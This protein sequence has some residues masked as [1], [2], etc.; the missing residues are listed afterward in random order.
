MEI[1]FSA[2][3]DYYKLKEN[4]NNLFYLDIETNFLKDELIFHE[5]I[6]KLIN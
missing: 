4:I 2:H 5:E 6:N 3:K 1:E